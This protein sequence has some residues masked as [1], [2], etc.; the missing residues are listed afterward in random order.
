MS[1]AKLINVRGIQENNDPFYR[2]KME[3]VIIVSEGVRFAFL[4]IETISE[5]LSRRPTE[6]V[7]FL[8]KYFGCQ[9]ELK[10][11]KVLTAKSDFSKN[12]LQEA[13]YNYIEKNVLCGTCKN[14]ETVQMQ[15][16]KK[17]FLVCQ[18]CSAKTLLN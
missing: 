15:E 13:I 4:N 3:E 12:V 2:Y 8:K 17:S 9:F 7:S 10:G 14:P 16:K 18:A 6:I 1:K 11:T 5:A